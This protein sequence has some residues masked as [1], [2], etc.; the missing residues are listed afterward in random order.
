M[1][2]V[3]AHDH[4]FVTD[5]NGIT[6]SRGKFSEKSF[7]IY[8]KYFES[9][10]I[11]G[12]SICNNLE[13][14]NTLSRVSSENICF[15]EFNNLSSFKSIINKRKNINTIKEIING[16]DVLISRLPSEIGLLAIDAAKELGVPYAVEVVACPWDGMWNYGSW[17]GKIY[18]PFYF[19]RNR[20]AINE[21]SNVIYVT[22]EFLQKRY[23]TK[24]F[25]IGVSD[26]EIERTYHELS[27]IRDTKW[28]SFDE[29]F[30]IGLIGS[31]DSPHKGF[32][33]AFKAISILKKQGLNIKFQIL[34]PGNKEKWSRH[35]QGI[36]EC[37]DFCGILPPGKEVI[38][39]LSN[40]DIYIQPSVQEGLP[41]A[42]LEAMSTGCPVVGSNAGGIPEL[43][44]KD[45]VH[46]KNDFL[47]LAEIIKEIVSNKEKYLKLIDHSLNVS[48]KYRKNS[49]FE[50]RNYFWNKVYEMVNSRIS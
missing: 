33:T 49:L 36:E 9:I 44:M 40:I 23:P 10:K 28:T 42:I 43:L 50:K 27:F 17:K 30:K 39:W 37:V 41:R 4:R 3:F 46:S 12:R 48:S 31:L 18:A 20:K 35:I 11:I 22:K 15:V 21:A 29:G 38:N 6:Y 8:L 14:D 25:N 24:G 34:G 1:K 19:L 7:S 45:V 16:C 47:E 13:F 26:V 32:D 5:V 2:A